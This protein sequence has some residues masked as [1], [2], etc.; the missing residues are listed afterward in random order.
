MYLRMYGWM[1]ICYVYML[2]MHECMHVSMDECMSC[3]YVCLS[4]LVRV[5]ACV[6]GYLPFFTGDVSPKTVQ[7]VQFS[8]FA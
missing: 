3:T 5:R 7:F 4:V 8:P 2:C 1:D 6:N